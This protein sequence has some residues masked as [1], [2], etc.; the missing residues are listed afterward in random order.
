MAW[1][2]IDAGT[3]VVKTVLFSDRGRELALARQSVPVLR[4][5]PDFAEQN[6]HAVWQAVVETCRAAVLAPSEEPLHAIVSTAQGDGV[7]LVDEALSPVGH[8]I[9]WNDGRA[10]PAVAQWH[11][12][13]RV[14]APAAISGS[15]PYAGLPC[16]ILPWLAVHEPERLARARW[17]LTANGW[18]HAQLA[19]RAIADLSDASNPFSD[20]RTR[21]YSPALL[22]HFGLAHLAHLLP[23]IDASVAP[24]A[25]LTANAA[26]EL[27]L[28]VGTPVVMAPY[29]IVTSAAGCGIVSPGES[30]IILG[31]T[32]CA[33]TI[34]AAPPPAG[35]P[36]GTTLALA[37]GLF[38]R[39][40]PTLTGCE[41]L[42]WAAAALA[43]DDLDE[44]AQL[45]ATAPAGAGGVLFLP[46]LSP[47]GERAPFLAPHARGSFHGLSL[48][49]TRAC[50]ARALFEGLSCAIRECLATASPTAPP[51]RIAVCG[52]GARSDLWCQMIADLCLC[53]VA[54]PAISEVGALGA[55][56]YA[57]T[58]L[59][60]ASSLR[61][62]H[63]SLAA[64]TQTFAPD[65]A[66]HR[67]YESVFRRFL[68]VRDQTAASWSLLPALDGGD[69][70]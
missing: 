35:P 67:I 49:H 56:V 31:T 68:R 54:R 3:S 69:L 27:G 37:N 39:A 12:E 4:P 20:L 1:L 14:D 32:I 52:G 53:E 60:R 51:H 5:A 65:H 47:A 48:A 50:L 70:G 24:V 41:A 19:S 2:S 36:S 26:R 66:R 44:L 8:A 61:D 43:I 55:L 42:T 11:A 57:Q 40:M 62:A 33:E 34:V 18:L 28:P 15:V 7:W 13:N 9:L 16:A 23:L 30:C 29:D 25:T 45:A 64:P 10:A 21:Q 22:R 6:M 58:A 38:L 63:Q 59:A 46:Y 17:A